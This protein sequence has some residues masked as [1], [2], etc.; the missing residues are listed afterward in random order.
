VH[1]RRQAEAHPE[2]KV[3]IRKYILNLISRSNNLFDHSETH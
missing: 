3:A 1:V 2:V